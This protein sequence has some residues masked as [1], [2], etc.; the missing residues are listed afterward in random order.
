MAYFQEALEGEK[1]VTALL[2][3]I[4]VFQVRKKF[5]EVINNRETLD[6]VRELT[7]TLQA[8]FD[9]RYVPTADESGTKLTFKWGTSLGQQNQYNTI[10]HFFFVAAFLD[11]RVKKLLMKNLMT[12]RDYLLL[13]HEIQKLVEAGARKQN[14]GREWNNDNEEQPAATQ[15]RT[16]QRTM[17]GATITPTFLGKTAIMFDGLIDMDDEEQD[18]E[19]GNNTENE[20]RD[21]AIEEI[22]RFDR[23]QT[24]PLVHPDGSYVNPL[25][26]WR[27]NSARFP[28]LSEL[29]HVYLAIPATSAPSERVWSRASRILTCKRSSMKP[30]V[31][32]GMMFLLEN[33]QVLHK[34]YKDIAPKYRNKEH[35]HLISLES[36]FLPEVDQKIEGDGIFN[37]GKQDSCA[38]SKE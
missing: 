19:P 6:P 34:H 4:A 30:E 17:N 32:Q 33:A 23:I 24:L 12:A 16:E 28:L 15:N 20:F 27:E 14:R 2:V 5:V 22:A 37:V 35:H 3:P 8:D 31:A 11:P 10:H 36:Q 9:K 25:P 18:D 38:A 7:K 13:K 21:M 29:A 1:Y 26:W